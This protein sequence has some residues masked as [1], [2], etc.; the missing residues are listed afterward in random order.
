MIA[1]STQRLPDRGGKVV[2]AVDGSPANRAAICW[3]ADFADA[4]HRAL[5]V[6]TVV[7]EAFRTS[8]YVSLGE[9]QQ[10]A[11]ETLDAAVAEATDLH[12]ALP[13]TTETLFGHASRTLRTEWPDADYVVLGR[14]G[15]G[16]FARMVLGSVSAAVGNHATLP[17]V[18]VPQDW[19]VGANSGLP[20]LA[21]VDGSTGGAHALD[22]AARLALA[23]GVELRLVHGWGPGTLFSS[24][25][26]MAYGGLQAWRKE[27]EEMTAAL[28][29]SVRQVYP[30]LVVT[31]LV[32]QAHPVA[33]LTEA[34]E[35]AQLLVVGGHRAGRMHA[36][37]VGSTTS[38]VLYHA[39]CPVLVV[40]VPH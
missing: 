6:V 38:G 33:E 32:Q 35:H 29:D 31:E 7:D 37:L 21:G 13:I 15:R 11:D 25:S 34:S 5:H 3:A 1:A 40:P 2:V 27:V 10:I 8:P 19:S 12:P 30:D 39:H 23:A 36:Q 9:I 14:R 16:G 18:V 22:E 17:T 28:A 20:I 26:V 24:E 4:S